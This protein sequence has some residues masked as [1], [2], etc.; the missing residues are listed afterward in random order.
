VTS[1]RGDLL[2]LAAAAE[3]EPYQQGIDTATA[4]PLTTYRLRAERLLREHRFMADLAVNHHDVRALGPRWPAPTAALRDAAGPIADVGAVESWD[5]AA[6]FLGPIELPPAWAAGRV[7]RLPSAACAFEHA[8]PLY[9]RVGQPPQRSELYLHDAGGLVH[10]GEARR[11]VPPTP[12]G[13]WDQRE[14]WILPC[15]GGSPMRAHEWQRSPRFIAHAFDP[16]RPISMA[17]TCQSP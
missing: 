3:H 5:F 11:L 10:V 17:L 7:A 2:E 6:A 12:L 13:P 14:R 8:G 9:L 4:R 16:A 15:G 1:P